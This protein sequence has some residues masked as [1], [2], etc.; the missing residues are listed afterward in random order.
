VDAP[1]T[2]PVTDPGYL[3]HK[4]Y[5]PAFYATVIRDWGSSLL[6]VQALGPPRALP[7]RSRA[8][9]AGRERRDDRGAAYRASGHRAR[10]AAQRP[11][12]V[13]GSGGIV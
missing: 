4:L 8:P 9:H 12:R 10:V 6:T 3:E 13:G 1:A 11:A 5:E 7:R 2:S